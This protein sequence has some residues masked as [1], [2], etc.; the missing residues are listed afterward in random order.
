[1]ARNVLVCNRT[2]AH[3]RLDA[4]RLLA[5]AS[6][7]ATFKR[8][9]SILAV[10]LKL[11]QCVKHGDRMRQPTT[12]G[13]YQYWNTVRNGRLAPRRYEIEPSQ[14]VPFLSETLIMEEP[15]D[16]C[17]IRVVGLQVC[18]WLGDNLRD[19]HFLDLWNTSD[20]AVLR[21][22]IRAV[23]QYGAVGLFTFAAELSDDAELAEFELLLLPLTHLEDHIERLLGSISLIDAP[24]WLATTIPTQLRLTSNE[25]IWP[26]GRPRSLARRSEPSFYSGHD[27]PSVRSEIGVRRARLVRHERRSF[28]VYDGGRAHMPPEEN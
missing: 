21:D 27:V 13:L 26:D 15:T 24:E 14:I 19:Q 23:T 25:L 9:N 6:H 8:D 20:Q 10:R 3:V 7:E 17:R 16:S 4:P 28:L 1:M 11:G 22:N 5:R 2:G 18:D 12:Q